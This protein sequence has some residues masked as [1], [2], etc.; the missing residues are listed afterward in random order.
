[1]HK[2]VVY[3]ILYSSLSGVYVA[4]TMAQGQTG[5]GPF[6]KAKCSCIIRCG[7][8]AEHFALGVDGERS[9]LLPFLLLP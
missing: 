1:M 3:V 9:D 6:G 5:V 8:I 2:N 4:I 7:I